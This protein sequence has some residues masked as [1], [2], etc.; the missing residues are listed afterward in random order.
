MVTNGEDGVV[1]VVDASDAVC[2]VERGPGAATAAQS[3]LGENWPKSKRFSL[4]RTM[5][6]MGAMIKLMI[7]TIVFTIDT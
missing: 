7:G 3:L 4:C 6:M 2:A 5:M 1:A